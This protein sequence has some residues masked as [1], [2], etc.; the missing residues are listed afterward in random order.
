MS[1]PGKRLARDRWA[2]RII[3]LVTG[4]AALLVLAIG[5]GLYLRSRPILD[6]HSLSTLLFSSSWRPLKG[7][8]GFFPFIAGTLWVTATAVIIAV[9]LCVLAAVFLAEYSPSRLR[10]A[11]KPLIDLLA[12][13]PSVIF[14]IWGVLVIVPL[15]QDRIAPLFGVF[16]SGYTVL[17]AGVVLAIMIFPVII[18]VCLEVFGSI[19]DGLRN[20]SLAL[21]ATRWET[22]KHVTGRK[23]FPGIIAAVVLGL[24]RAFGETMAVLMVA[25]NVARVP[26]SLFD[27][28]YP[29]PALLAN[30]YGEM[31]S[32]PLYDSAL[33]FSALVLMA[34]VVFFNVVSRMV[35]VRVERRI[36]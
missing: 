23:A 5:A 15:V 2:G 32:V 17:T 26:S 27:P 11:A 10:E 22:I 21:G 7:E 30:N 31:L 6:G 19:E 35:L 1:R 9:P 18:H 8:F 24:S 29:L 4:A 16:S 28:A 14:G 25:G 13:I 33:L 3:F 36:S 34:V 12:G 20:A